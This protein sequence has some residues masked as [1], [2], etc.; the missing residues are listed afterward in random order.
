MKLLYQILTVLFWISVVF[1]GLMFF[2]NMG[3]SLQAQSNS[4]LNQSGSNY[5]AAFIGVFIANATIPGI[6]WVIRHFVKKS[7]NNE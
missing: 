6:I 1:F 5:L 2:L 7:L 4:T 3:M